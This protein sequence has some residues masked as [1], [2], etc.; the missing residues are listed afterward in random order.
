MKRRDFLVNGFLVIGALAVCPVASLAATDHVYKL[1]PLSMLPDGLRNAPPESGM[2]ID[3]P[4][5]IEK[6]SGTF[7][8]T[9]AAA[10]RA[11]PAMRHVMSR[12]NRRPINQSSIQ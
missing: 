10:M 9:A 8:V 4:C 1:A 7:R 6:P 12:I 3:S 5:S 11:I 2:R